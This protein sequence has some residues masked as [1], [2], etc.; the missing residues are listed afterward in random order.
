MTTTF[1]SISMKTDQ[2]AVGAS[3]AAVGLKLEE[4]DYKYLSFNW[5]PNKMSQNEY[6]RFLDYLQSKGI[7][8]EEDK[9]Y[10]G[11]GGERRASFK[12]ETWY[13]PLYPPVHDFADGNVLAYVRYQS[14]I[15]YDSGTAERK[16]EVDL[17]KKITMIMEEMVKRK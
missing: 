7:L 12:P 9:K 4:E 8:S 1:G 5:N 6:D 16:H 3:T 11:Y 17:Y 13:S 10:V 15:I 2:Y 14:S